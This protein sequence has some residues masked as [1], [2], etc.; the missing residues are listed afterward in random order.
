[1]RELIVQA[2]EQ[3]DGPEVV[4]AGDHRGRHAGAAADPGRDDK[5]VERVAGLLGHCGDG[6]CPAVAGRQ[7][8]DDVGVFDVDADHTVALGLDAAA[9][10][11][12]DPPGRSRDRDDSHAL[13]LQAPRRTKR[14]RR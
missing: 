11:A 13:P 5:T 1:M 8:G 2:L 7:V 6:G 12:A 4:D 14:T 3:R 10:R 9:D